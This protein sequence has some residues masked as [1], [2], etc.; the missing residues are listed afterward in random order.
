MIKIN[1]SK[2]WLIQQT[3]SRPDNIAV[4]SEMVNFTYKGLLDLCTNIAVF[5]QKAGIGKEDNV[6]L[7]LNHGYEFYIIINALWLIGAVPVPLNTRN[8]KKE[9]ESQFEQVNIKFLIHTPSFSD[10]TNEDFP[11]VKKIILPQS[12]KS[13]TLNENETVNYSTLSALHSSL[14]LFTSGSSGKP[15]AVVHTFKSLFESV[16]TI[17]SFSI[18]S[19]TDVWL[20]SLPVYHIGG[21]MILIRALITGGT[22][23]FPQSIKYED[24]VNAILKFQPSHISLV[25][26]TLKRFLE[27]KVKPP[28]NPMETELCID[29]IKYGWPIVKVYGSTETCSMISALTPDELKTKPDSAGKAMGRNEITVIHKDH[30]QKYRFTRRSSGGQDQ[31]NKLKIGEIV[32]KSESLFKEY[33][34]DPP[35]TNK[36]L[37]D[38]FYF[39]GDSGRLDDEGYLYIESRREDLVITGG[40]NVSTKEVETII[41]TFSGVTDAYVFGIPDKKWGQKLCAAVTAKNSIEPELKLFLRNEIA[42]YKIPK[43]FFFVNE[44]PKTEMGKVN[45]LL[46]F[47]ILN[48]G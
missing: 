25:T 6:G 26:T 17:D 18:L 19:S 2:Q 31:N 16:K 21:F 48:L 46:L 33:Y 45:R 1:N 42:G 3:A 24:I 36:K 37:K 41:K 39:T 43:E 13:I 28:E 35:S 38:G 15:K 27:D 23:V 7:L 4:K 40:E 30:D 14:I 32:V 10:E 22:V 20:S 44:I 11:D 8:S 5:I 47:E 29:A 9:I 34:N 12:F